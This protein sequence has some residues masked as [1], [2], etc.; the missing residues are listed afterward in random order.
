[1]TDVGTNSSSQAVAVNL[2]TPAGTSGNEMV[3]ESEYAVA[4]QIE[5]TY[6]SI[7]VTLPSGSDPTA[8]KVTVSPAA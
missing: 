2:K 3:C 1:V 8:V 5:S 6:K 7:C 4:Y